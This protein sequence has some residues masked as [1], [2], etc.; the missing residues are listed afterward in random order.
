MPR[1]EPPL[2]PAE[3]WEEED[4]IFTVVCEKC[5]EVLINDEPVFT[6]Y[7]T[8]VYCEKCAGQLDDEDIDRTTARDY[9]K[10]WY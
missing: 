7:P 3:A 9:V 10:G 8:H 5:G 6:A 1:Y 4:V 2:E